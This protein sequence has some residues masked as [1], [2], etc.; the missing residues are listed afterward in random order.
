MPTPSA[1]CSVWLEERIVRLGF[2]PEAIQVDGY[3]KH[4]VYKR[5]RGQPIRFSTLDY[6]GLLTVRNPETFLQ[7][8]LGGVGHAK[9]FGCWVELRAR[10]A[11]ASEID[12]LRNTRLPAAGHSEDW[13]REDRSQH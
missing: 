8:L 5:G 13:I 3:P 9:A 2:T 10:Q 11:A 4:R 1:R 12:R 6:T 7:S